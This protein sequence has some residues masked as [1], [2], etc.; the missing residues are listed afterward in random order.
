MGNKDEQLKSFNG[1]SLNLLLH[2]I[3]DPSPHSDLQQGSVKGKSH[4]KSQLK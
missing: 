1:N 4:N 2:S 3:T